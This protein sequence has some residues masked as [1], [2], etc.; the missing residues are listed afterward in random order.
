MID[1]PI[2]VVPPVISGMPAPGSTLS[3]DIGQWSGWP[4]CSHQWRR[5]AV[6]IP[7]ATGST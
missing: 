2:N 3:A 5:D 7:G 6:D 4:T 1:P